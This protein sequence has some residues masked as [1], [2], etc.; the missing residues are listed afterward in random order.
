MPLNLQ[1]SDWRL[2]AV[3][4]LCYVLVVG[5]LVVLELV[6][7]RTALDHGIARLPQRD[8]ARACS[9][10]RPAATPTVE[11]APMLGGFGVQV[12]PR[13]RS[14]HA[15]RPTRRCRATT[16]PTAAQR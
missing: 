6:V 15:P 10:A 16:C 14:G 3:Q 1:V 13:A 5:Y 12:S 7:Y 9:P 2:A 4:K 8:A 11:I